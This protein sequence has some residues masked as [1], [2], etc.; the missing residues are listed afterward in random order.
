MLVYINRG[1]FVGAS[2][3][4]SSCPSNSVYVDDEINSVLEF[5]L[6]LAG[7]HV[8]DIDDDGDSPESYFPFEI[9]QLLVYQELAR[10]LE[11][12]NVFAKDLKK[13]FYIFPDTVYSLLM[14]KQIDHPP[15]V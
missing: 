1:L 4:T 2:E 11:Q 6:K 14:Y 13:K 3:I 9:R 15:E 5:V 8:N 12:N 7:C 10:M